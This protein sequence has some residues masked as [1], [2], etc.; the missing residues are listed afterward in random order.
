MKPSTLFLLALLI[1]PAPAAE[2][3]VHRIDLGEAVL[4]LPAG[5]RPRGGRAD[6]IVHMHGAA[7]VVEKALNA[8]GW[9]GPLLL[10]NRKG[11][12]SVYTEPF[13]D[14]A[15]FSRLL[16]KAQK[17][18]TG[19]WPADDPKIGRVFVSS[20]SA[21]FGGVRE[22]LAVPAHFARIDGVILADSLYA[23]YLGDV[24]KRQID[25]AKMVGFRKFAAE[26]AAG[27]KT[28]IVTHSAQVP[29][30]YAS[31]TETA[32]DL[33]GQVGG[34]AEA[35]DEDW[36]DG[37][38]L[39]RRFAKGRF[40]VLGFAGAGPEDHMRHLRRLD[41]IWRAAVEVDRGVPMIWPATPMSAA[42][43]TLWSKRISD[44]RTE[45]NAG[46]RADFL[47]RRLSTCRCRPE[48]SILNPPPADLSMLS[49]PFQVLIQL[50]GF[51]RPGPERAPHFDRE[52]R[53]L[54][55]GGHSR[56]RQLRMRLKQLR[57]RSCQ[58][59]IGR[60]E[61]RPGVSFP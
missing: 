13:R 9:T 35:V 22:L 30:G 51:F 23:G 54:A 12:S 34:K 15:L 25:P 43:P 4:V 2:D 14:P 37:W 48:N 6:V 46:R 58:P 29:T 52:L 47:L 31:T 7:P 53:V 32:D 45:G 55:Q 8:S 5:Y 19:A 57:A 10:F 61:H 49:C 27:R 44:L 39:K 50:L 18:I 59:P 33:I 36:G 40:L 56:W 26:A 1:V 28:M 24:A 17:E 3:A 38:R 20:F 16:A 42:H 41:K 21:G 11:L 60:R